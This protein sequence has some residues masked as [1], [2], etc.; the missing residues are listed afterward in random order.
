MHLPS[1]VAEC[2]LVDEVRFVSLDL[3]FALGLVFS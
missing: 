2:T 1:V 3:G